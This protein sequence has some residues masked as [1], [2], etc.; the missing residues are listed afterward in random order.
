VL[1]LDHVNLA[2]LTS[3]KFMSTNNIQDR[4]APWE[5]TVYQ[6]YLAQN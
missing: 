6:N 2:I 3:S 4:Q 1:V 5:H